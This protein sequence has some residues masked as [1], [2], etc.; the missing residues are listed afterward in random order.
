MAAAMLTM[1][2]S[3]A[4]QVI[5]GGTPGPQG[6]AG[7]GDV[8]EG[9]YFVD[10]FGAVGDG[11]TDDGPEITAALAA[12]ISNPNGGV[13]I[14]GPGDYLI[15]SDSL[16]ITVDSIILRGSG[17][18]AI[19]GGAGVTGTRLIFDHAAA[20]V[21]PSC[22]KIGHQAATTTGC[23]IE[24]MT[25]ESPDTHNGHLVW[26]RDVENCFVNNCV[27]ESFSSDAQ[28]TACLVIDSNLDIST[29]NWADHVWFLIPRFG[30]GTGEGYGLL[31]DQIGGAD[32]FNTSNNFYACKFNNAS[33]PGAS[34]VIRST[35]G[36]ECNNHH[37]VSCQ[38]DVPGKR[39]DGIDTD[40]DAGIIIDDSNRNNFYGC[41]IDKSSGSVCVELGQLKSREPRV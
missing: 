29:N 15:V 39:S 33:E 17:T 32:K 25:V 30:I 20:S 4:G 18:S 7:A 38:I 19:P 11:L 6:A 31:L 41:T 26:M 37:F 14:F 34:I 5:Y 8:W 9:Y 2:C 3:A 28:G 16:E 13:V 40:N 24:Y 36:S 21:S 10:A 23:G 35:G 1:P 27:L 22:I 12:A